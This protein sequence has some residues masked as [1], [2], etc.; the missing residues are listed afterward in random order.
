MRFLINSRIP[1]A[2]S[3]PLYY[4]RAW[5]FPP[6]RRRVGLA[7]S[8]RNATRIQRDLPLL[9]GEK[10]RVGKKAR[11]RGREGQNRK[12]RCYI[13]MCI[14]TYVRAVFSRRAIVTQPY[15]LR[16]ARRERTYALE[17]GPPLFQIFMRRFNSRAASRALSLICTCALYLYVYRIERPGGRGN[18]G[19]KGAPIKCAM[20][21]AP[22]PSSLL[23]LSSNSASISL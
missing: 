23:S 12:G 20:R 8:V 17:S 18:N 22:H 3:H 16:A 11:T 21:L 15:I 13:R 2:S 5:F 6:R 10:K 19:H 7:D 1:Q 14:Y 9:R 4:L